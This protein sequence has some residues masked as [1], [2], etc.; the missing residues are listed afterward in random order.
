MLLKKNAAK[1][2]AK[3]ALHSLNS[4]RTAEQKLLWGFIA[5]NWIFVLP[6]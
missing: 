6:Q 1:L 3:A 5:A 2:P 4:E